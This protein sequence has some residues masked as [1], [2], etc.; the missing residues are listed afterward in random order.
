M[1]EPGGR[2][3]R[4][5]GLAGAATLVSR[6]LGLARETL[7]AAFFGAGNQMD[8]YFVAFR[9]PNLVR[10]LFAEGAMSAAFVPTFTRHLTLHGKDDAW[11]LGINLMT[12][13]ALVTGGLAVAG[14][15]F[16]PAIVGAYA[17]AFSAVPGKME[18]TVQLTRVMLPFLPLAALAAAAMG[19]LNSL[20]YY[21]V[22]ALAPATFNVASILCLVLLVPLM[23]SFGW[24]AIMAAAI[25]VLVGGLAQVAV[26]WPALAREGFRYRPRLDLRD[27]GLQRVLLLM[28]PGTIGLA[29]TQ[30]NLFVNT[31][32]ATSQGPGAP[33]WLSY[34]FRLMYL[35][36]GLFGVSIATAVLPA[37]ARH[38][39]LDD[40]AAV[41]QTL[42]RGL[43]LMLLLNVPATV[44]LV[45][46]ATP[47]VRLLFERGQFL[48]SDTA[49]TASVL[50]CYAVGLVGYA[51]A[52]IASPV[53]YALGQH[54]VPV[55]VSTA[56][57]GVNV[58][59]SLLLVNVMGVRGLALGTSIA[60]LAHGL[61]AVWLLR[62]RLQGI[63]GVRMIWTLG[64]VALASTVMAA[65]V[66]A[67]DRWSALLAPGGSVVAQTAR[68]GIAIGAGV[69]ALVLSA[70]LLKIEELDDALARARDWLGSSTAG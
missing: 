31:L 68:L 45:V 10:D 64:K 44:G 12:A 62:R 18:L 42:S 60:A 19:M 9:I 63:G 5:A 70:R 43:G 22:P 48:P 36:I 37:A 17:G 57:V 66:V 35:P 8:A 61:S 59:A 54:R 25:G 23:P 24:P 49:A 40:H 3:A 4:S 41:R 6:L 32:L 65:V 15:T 53:F 21:F 7:L 47:I 55:A 58:L 51:A 16:A 56:S 1:T 11:R 52:R 69:A 39:A 30:I 26:Q 29:A 34:A 2:L 20:H 50:Q 67:V 28:G 14:M 33:S 38:A 13:L 27:P 46:L